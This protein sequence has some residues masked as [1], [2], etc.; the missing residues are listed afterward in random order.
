[1]ARGPGLR[2]WNRRNP[3]WELSLLFITVTDVSSRNKERW[4]GTRSSTIAEGPRD[5]LCQSKSCPLPHSCRNK[6]YKKS[7]TKR[8]YGVGGLQSTDMY[9]AH[10]ASTVLVWSTSS[11]VDEFCWH[12]ISTVTIDLPW[13]NNFLRPEFVTEFQREEPLFLKLLEFPYQTV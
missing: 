6:L 11:T 10:D 2:Q 9:C 3:Q 8:S 1:M 12:T 13:R 4:Q 5:A 7:T